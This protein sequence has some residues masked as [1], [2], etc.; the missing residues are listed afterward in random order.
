M[1]GKLYGIGIG[2][3]DPELLTLKAVRILQSVDIVAV[4]ESKTEK[5]S[6]ALEIVRKHI[7]EN[8]EIVMLTFPMI[9]DEQKKHKHRLQNSLV[10]KDLIASG[11]TA[12]FLTIGDPML[13]S[14]FIYLFE[15]LK[16]MGIEI[17]TIPGISAHSAAASMLNIPLAIQNQTLAIVPM[18]KKTDIE[19][20]LERF[21][22]LVVLKASADS[23]R[24]GDA[25]KKFGGLDITIASKIGA[26]DE[27]TS[28][29]VH[30]LYGD[31]PYLTT[32]IIKRKGIH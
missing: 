3:G 22:N 31:L 17:E 30:D 11:K 10:L 27:F 16:D 5:G 13:Y 29:D 6:F 18:N 21:D 24:L 23:R 28:K 12:A 7:K 19:D 8:A 14:T 25:V 4:P 15:N 32:V 26:E 1:K 2:P 20:M 9:K